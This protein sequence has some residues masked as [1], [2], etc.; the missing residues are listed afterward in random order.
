MYF[1]LFVLSLAALALALGFCVQ[2]KAIV[3]THRCASVLLPEGGLSA[4]RLHHHL[5]QMPGSS[6]N[7]PPETFVHQPILR[8]LERLDQATL[9]VSKILRAPEFLG[10]F[11]IEVEPVRSST[12]CCGLDF[13][14]CA[15]A[16]HAFQPPPPPSCHNGTPHSR[17]RAGDLAMLS[18]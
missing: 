1:N 11:I 2:S 3:F 16:H 6:E 5:Q 8:L 7:D 12:T 10:R 18:C 15:L 4:E 14:L 17:T 13:R 9:F